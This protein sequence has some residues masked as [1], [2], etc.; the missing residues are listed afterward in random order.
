M[1]FITTKQ[2][3]LTDELLLVD[4][5]VQLGRTQ[6]RLNHQMYTCQWHVLMC[7]SWWENRNFV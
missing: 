7:I 4:R 1:P 2:D 5:S 3:T 6:R